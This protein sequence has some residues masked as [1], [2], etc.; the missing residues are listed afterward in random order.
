[1]RRLIP[2]EKKLNMP[3]FE[4]A[5]YKKL[6]ARYILVVQ[7][8]LSIELVFS[9]PPLNCWPPFSTPNKKIL[10]PPLPLRYD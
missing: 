7:Y 9:A 10:E 8:F 6:I 3:F 4:A 2:Q 1:M 5:V